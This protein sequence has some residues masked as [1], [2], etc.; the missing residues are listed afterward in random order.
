MR[1]VAFP[2]PLA[3]NSKMSASWQLV[4]SV[5]ETELRGRKG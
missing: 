5:G 4:G 3:V 1:E 2:L